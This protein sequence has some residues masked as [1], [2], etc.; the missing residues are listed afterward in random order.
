MSFSLSTARIYA[1]AFRA[2]QWVKNTLV[3]VPLVL[4]GKAYDLPS[5]GRV[6]LGFVALSVLTSATYLVNDIRDLDDD[7]RHWSKRN[8]P[9][10]KGAISITQ[11]A[12]LACVGVI[13]SFAIGLA[14][15]AGTVAML[16]LYLTAS[17]AYSFWLKRQPILDVLTVASLFT[18]R[19]GLGVVLGEVRFSPWLFV[20]SMFLFLSLSLAK[21]FNEVAQMGEHGFARALGRGYQTSDEPIVLA[22]GAAAMLGAVLILVIYLIEEAF[23]AEFYAQPAFLWIIP[24]VLFLWLGRVW[25]LSHRHALN[26]DPVVFALKDKTSLCYGALVVIAV[27]AAIL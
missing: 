26:D 8:R 16:T 4:G 2:H 25:L 21:R 22:L 9:L 14:L 7:R 1:Q 18:V 12:V 19:L 6:G 24:V 5:W 11:A 15:G 27:A 23:P 20:F 10:A 3:A 17:L 13:V